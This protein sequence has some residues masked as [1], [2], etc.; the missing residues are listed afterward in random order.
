MKKPLRYVAPITSPPPRN[1]NNA[2]V[3]ESESLWEQ[4]RFVESF[5]TLLDALNPE[6][7]SKYGNAEGTEFHVPHGSVVIDI[8]LDEQGAHFTSEFLNIPAEA[9]HRVP[10][11]RQLA[12]IN[13]Q[14]LILPKFEKKGNRLRVVY[15][16]LLSQLHPYKVHAVIANMCNVGDE[17]DDLFCTKFG[18]TRCYT[19]KVTHYDSSVISRV[20]RDLND[21][22]SQTLNEVEE[23]N[24]KRL[25]GRSYIAMQTLL[26][27][28]DYFLCPQGQLV[29]DLDDAID[30][31][32]EQGATILNIVSK[33]ATFVKQLAQKSEEE[34]AR[35]LYEV[36]KFIPT[37]RMSNIKS[38]QQFIV[39][40][41]KE[42][43]EALE[44][45]N[46]EGCVLR[47]LYVFYKLFYTFDVQPEV[48]KL[49]V[50]AL[51]NAQNL[52]MEQAALT[53][54]TASDKIIDG[55]V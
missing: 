18:A 49:L 28:L 3:D 44:V 7:R 10:M 30:R 33:A 5:H 50:A 38:V 54:F 41:Y 36:E 21:I 40:Y 16:C 14:E 52:D 17:Y 53:L 25:Y 51:E 43:A 46:F 6:I 35:D 8:V 26:Y 20:R 32:E 12:A 48:A 42:A 15:H 23:S 4:G 34:L 47:L 27:Q 11:M 37:K 55:E 31:M 39:P 29:N 22:V 1:I 9:E 19:P 13:V 45:R 2:L 24:R